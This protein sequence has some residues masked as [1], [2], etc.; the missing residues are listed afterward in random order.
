[1]VCNFE[2]CYQF[3]NNSAFA[4]SLFRCFI[5]MKSVPLFR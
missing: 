1:M 5:F 4:I 2:S 3:A